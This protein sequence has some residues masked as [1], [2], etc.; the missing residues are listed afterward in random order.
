MARFRRGGGLVTHWTYTTDIIG[1]H[2]AGT[3]ARTLAPAVHETETVLRIRGNLFANLDG[4][5]APGIMVEVGVGIVLVPEGT[6]TT[7][8][9]SPR[10]DGDAPWIW[11]EH[12]ALAYDETVTDAIQAGG[13]FFRAVIDNKAMRKMRNQELQLVVE[14]TTLLTASAINVSVQARFLSGK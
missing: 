13:G 2:A 12:F 8:L 3:A 4:A 14:N 5:Q 7:V 10:A 6:G 9:W 11:V 1:A